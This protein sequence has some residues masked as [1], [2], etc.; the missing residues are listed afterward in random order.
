[1]IVLPPREN[2]YEPFIIDRNPTLYDLV[3]LYGCTFTDLFGNYPI[4]DEQWRDWL[5]QEIYAYFEYR[6]IGTETAEMFAKFATR[7]MNRI[8]PKVNSIAAFALSG[9]TDWQSTAR[10]HS[11]LDSETTYGRTNTETRN[12]AGSS[13]TSNT[14]KS[15]ALQSDTPQTALTSTENYMTALA[16][17]GSS[18]SASTTTTDTGTDINATS[19]K[20]STANESNRNLSAGQLSELASNWVATMP[21]LLALVFESLENCFMQV[22]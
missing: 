11:T 1:M 21:D 17:T 8:M 9:S 15:T 20:D 7:R 18:G 5:N 19:G 2:G 12:L 10:D 4:W 22:Y 13:S 6:E 16:E 14:A 3:E